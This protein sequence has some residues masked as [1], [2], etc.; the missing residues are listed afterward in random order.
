MKHVVGQ[1][2]GVAPCR[3]YPG[4]AIAFGWQ[5]EGDAVV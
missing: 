3:V 4:K 5:V 1:G 2:A